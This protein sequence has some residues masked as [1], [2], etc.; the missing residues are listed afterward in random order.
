MF[1]DDYIVLPVKKAGGAME[2]V[3]LGG[4]GNGG[5]DPRE[6]ASLVLMKSGWRETREDLWLRFIETL[7]SHVKD[8]R[9]AAETR[10]TLSRAVEK[11]GL[12]MSPVEV[13]AVM[14]AVAEVRQGRKPGARSQEK[15]A[16]QPIGQ[17]ARRPGGQ[18]ALGGQTTGQQA[19]MP[20]PAP[21]PTLPPTAYRLPPVVPTA[22]P[23]RET[24]K[25]AAELL[26]KALPPKEAVVP[27][28]I[29]ERGVR[30]QEISAGQ[31][32]GQPAGMPLPAPKP[33][34]PPTAYRQPPVVPTAP[35]N[36]PVPAMPAAPPPRESVPPLPASRD[37][38]V[39][40]LT[41]EI[42]TE[43]NLRFPER[44]LEDRLRM[45]VGARLRD[46][47]DEVETGEV[48][49]KPV[50]AG[51]LGLGSADLARVKAALE[52]RV[53]RIHSELY[54]RQKG[55][56]I[57]ALAKEREQD[58]FRQDVRKEQEKQEID[59]LFEQV[60]GKTATPGSQEVRRPGG[61]S[62][63][64]QPARPVPV[65]PGGPVVRPKPAVAPPPPAPTT[66]TDVRRPAGLV[67]PIEELRRLT[68]GDFR[69]LSADPREATRRI[70]DKLR[71][72][73]DLSLGEKFQGIAALKESD[74]MTTY[75]AMTR[76][77]MAGGSSIDEI[78][79]SR[80]QAA[81]PTLTREEFDAIMDL[82]RAVRF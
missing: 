51:G 36:L 44:Y 64:S 45:A 57:E 17:E 15:P 25:K 71:L 28:K 1:D 42:M 2:V 31:T 11:G 82:N 77:S 5:L 33:T 46:I 39:V 69:K 78:I 80:T 67:G 61:P 14:A 13:D 16:G 76:A 53:A 24:L 29:E 34:L 37:E 18:G 40:M 74:L 65:P 6:A 21:K 70:Q 58:R 4:N 59:S 66:M 60:T 62:V 50:N 20:S 49:A 52:P 9:D 81:L 43:L 54:E 68:V 23:P 27:V 55:R 72:L 48:L 32:A 63:T 73:E 75:Y 79:A 56:T 47:R 8:V 38:A 7:V 12:G 22:P 35:A 19:G 41:N 26:N 30:G 3:K 10:E